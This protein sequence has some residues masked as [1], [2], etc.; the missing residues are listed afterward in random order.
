MAWT[1]ASTIEGGVTIDLSVMKGL[2]VSPDKSMVS[3]EPGNRWSEVYSRLEPLGIAVS[4]GRWGNVGVGGL[5]TG[6]M[7]ISIYYWYT[8]LFNS[9]GLS[10]FQGR[11]GPAC[12]GV[13]NHE[14]VLSDGSI[15]EA[16]SR[17]NSDLHKA[18]KG[19]N[20]NFGI[21]SRFDLKAFPQEN[22]WGG[23]I[24]DTPLNDP[25]ALDWFQTFTN[26]SENFDPYGMVMFGAGPAF[27]YTV[28]GGLITYSKPEPKP[29]VFKKLY[30]SSLIA[31]TTITTYTNI[32]LM[33]GIG[34]PSGGRVEWASFSFKNSAAFMKVV[35]ELANAKSGGPPAFS[36]SI[37]LIFQPLWHA[38]R[39]KSFAATG[40][41]SLGLEGTKDDLVIVL[42]SIASLIPSD[43]EVV[44]AKLKDFLAAITQKAKE[45]GVYSPYIYANYAAGFQD[46]IGGYGE[47]S[48]AE[49]IATSKKYD[50]IQLFQKQVPGGFKLVPKT[51]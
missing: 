22:I 36:S 41:N 26:S 6:G 51:S 19:G 30:D 42:V 5:L 48:R 29:P 2:K 34:T 7:M 50:P 33:N 23:M 27:G 14:V 1:G 49:M 31:M 24:L 12:D 25:T 18:L 46:V 38:S 10:F 32:A 20:N 15:V 9:G 8:Y 17:N 16:N 44:D 40:G 47:K 45:M 39:A 43:D 28:G 21:V 11:E 3:L 37:S 35:I 4:G 13:I